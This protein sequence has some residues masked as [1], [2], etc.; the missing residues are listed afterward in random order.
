MAVNTSNE[1]SDGDIASM[2]SVLRGY[3]P[4]RQRRLIAALLILC[5]LYSEA[6]AILSDIQKQNLAIDKKCPK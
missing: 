1:P 6:Q 2:Y 3:G 4:E 5:G